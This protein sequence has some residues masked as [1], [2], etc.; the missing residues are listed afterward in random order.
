[1]DE[2]VYVCTGT[3]KAEITQ[4]QYDGGLTKCGAADCSMHGQPFEKRH[5]HEDGSIHE[6]H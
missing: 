5:K 4:D 1:M 3:C 2:T 6:D